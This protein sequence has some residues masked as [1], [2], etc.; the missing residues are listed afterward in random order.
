MFTPNCAWRRGEMVEVRQM[1][2]KGQSFI[3]LN[4]S[5]LP[6][7]MYLVLQLRYW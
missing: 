1:E 2:M 3:L 4:Y 7:I 5:W 6:P